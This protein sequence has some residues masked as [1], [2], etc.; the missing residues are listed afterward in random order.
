MKGDNYGSDDGDFVSD[1]DIYSDDVDCND[2]S[3]E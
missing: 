2:Y 1:S 3:D